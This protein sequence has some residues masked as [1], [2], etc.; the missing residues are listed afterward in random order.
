MRFLEDQI[1]LALTAVI[2][3]KPVLTLSLTFWKDIRISIN[4]EV[5]F[6]PEL[7]KNIDSN[8]LEK[9]KN[10]TRIWLDIHEKVLYVEANHKKIVDEILIKTISEIMDFIKTNGGFANNR[11]SA[12]YKWYRDVANTA[13]LKNEKFAQD[14][15][16]I[17]N[18]MNPTINHPN[19]HYKTVRT[20]L[21]LVK[22]RYESTIVK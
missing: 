10:F 3:E 20:L 6:N 19:E 12:I 16:N 9:V 11:L 2:L 17:R 15:Y 1:D 7:I 13:I 5:K 8:V 18:F 4:D 21:S 14:L 22:D